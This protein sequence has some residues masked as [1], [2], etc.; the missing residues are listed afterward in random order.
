MLRID[1]V[2]FPT[3]FSDGA[4]RAFPQAAFLAAWHDA[5]LHILNVTGRH[6]HD[7]DEAKRRF[8]VPPDTLD[9]WLR[10]PAQDVAGTEWPDL[11]ALSLEQVQVESATP[12]DAILTYADENAIDLVVMGTHGRRGV[13]RM[14]FGS[15]TE[16]VVRRASCP[17]LTV[18]ADTDVA[19]GQAV[20]R[21]LVPIDF[22]DA[23]GP[24]L[25]HAREI[26]L[27]YGA[28]IDLLHVVEEPAYPA[29]YGPDIDPF[30]TQDV[31]DRVEDQLATMARNDIGIE[32][33]QVAARAGHGP[34]T[35]LDY[36]EEREADLIVIATHGRTGLD[37]A[38]LGSVAE[39]VLRQ[40]P[41]PVF[42]VKPE[43]TSMVPPAAAA[44]SREA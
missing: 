8:P 19:P 33:V 32:H 26:A 24:A 9:D 44:A 38:L 40:S 21:V 15:V 23:S 37:R 10:R 2:L 34:S 12:A 41:V 28:E 43:R 11:S 36:G 17:V 13:D 30:P 35:I 1:H 20:R 39:R 18:R 16:K 42:V 5:T 3:D 29:A 7:Y 27:T 14:L 25:D 4:K 6:R 22:S 31:L